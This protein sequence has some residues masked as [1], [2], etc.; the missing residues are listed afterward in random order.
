LWTERIQAE[1][2]RRSGR[3]LGLFDHGRDVCV[4]AKISISN[5]PFL[6]VRAALKKPVKR[7]LTGHDIPAT[8]WVI[9]PKTK[10]AGN[11]W[12]TGSIGNPI[13]RRRL[14]RDN[15]RLF[16]FRKLRS[17]STRH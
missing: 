10:N 11:P 4:Y 2:L 8:W 12:M 13:S 9:A 17:T 1:G 5:E 3:E 7:F 14:P 15:C 6:A 16:C